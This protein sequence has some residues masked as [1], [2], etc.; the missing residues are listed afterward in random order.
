MNRKTN[1]WENEAAF[2]KSWD[3]FLV[4]SQLSLENQTSK[5][6]LES[7]KWISHIL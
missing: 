3:I 6:N 5:E 1:S 7:I 2:Q 4:L